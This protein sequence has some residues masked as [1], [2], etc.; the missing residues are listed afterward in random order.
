MKNMFVIASQFNKVLGVVDAEVGQADCTFVY[1]NVL[2]WVEL[3]CAG[4]EDGL[5]AWD[6]LSDTDFDVSCGSS[7]VRGVTSSEISADDTHENQKD[8]PHNNTSPKHQQI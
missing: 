7:G 4:L 1:F 8:K 3:T 6:T 5:Q 2:C